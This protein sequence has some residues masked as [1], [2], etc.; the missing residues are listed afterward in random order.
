MRLFR[1]KRT[2]PLS[3]FDGNKSSDF[4][5]VKPNLLLKNRE[6]HPDIRLIASYDVGES[7]SDQS[8][9][10]LDIISSLVDDVASAEDPSSHKATSALRQLFT[11]SEQYS[12]NG[13][14]IVE[15]VK[16]LLDFLDRCLKKENHKSAALYPALLVLNSISIALEN[17]RIIVLDLNGT[18]ALCRI[19]MHDPSCHMA[20]IVLTNLTFTNGTLRSEIVLAESSKN[21]LIPTLAYV[22]RVGSLSRIEYEELHHIIDH[23]GDSELVTAQEKLSLLVLDDVKRFSTMASTR[24]ILSSENF[25]FADTVR[26]SL[27]V[28]NNLSRPGKDSQ[29]AA[30]SLIRCGII[31]HILRLIRV[32]EE[33]GVLSCNLNSKSVAS[34]TNNSLHSKDSQT[35]S[36][37]SHALRRTVLN[38][39]SRWSSQL[40]QDTALFIIMNISSVSSTIDYLLHETPTVDIMLRVIRFYYRFEKKRSSLLLTEVDDQKQARFQ[41]LKAR[42][43][44]SY[45]LGSFGHFGQRHRARIDEGKYGKSPF[46]INEKILILQGES[47]VL[48]LVELVANS[49]NQNPKEGPGGY[50]SV[51]FNIKYVLFALR[52]MLTH[53]KNQSL[54]G[55]MTVATKLNCLLL[56]AIAIYR[57]NPDANLIDLEAAEFA[58]FSLY[59]L[60]NFGFRVSYSISTSTT[61][62]C[63]LV[64]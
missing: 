20:L 62:K 10:F 27:C 15:M 45:L 41:C 46:L 28:M 63:F 31:P 59:L 44:L 48:S 34:S 43:I 22:L 24:A 57:F 61:K 36:S 52:C 39:P 3:D 9:K 38:P 60:S 37:P 12:P 21:Q 25:V 40:A 54:I 23:K 30:I 19:L 47:E 18:N 42:I 53:P 4:H 64:I 11:F 56:K 16:A 5:Y 32:Q 17:K 2:K 58:C 50:L 13:E 7:K 29:T 26:W 14:Q 33:K 55:G 8:Y 49:L 1:F 35:E 51:M 6:S